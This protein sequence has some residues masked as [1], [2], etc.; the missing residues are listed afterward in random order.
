MLVSYNPNMAAEKIPEI[1]AVPV[2]EGGWRGAVLHPAKQDKS[3]QAFPRVHPLHEGKR[4]QI[5]HTDHRYSLHDL[6]F[7]GNF[8]DACYNIG[9][10]S[11]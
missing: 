10:H 1:S 4:A 11:A 9:V 3:Q 8:L 7:S 5:D 2:S 6:G